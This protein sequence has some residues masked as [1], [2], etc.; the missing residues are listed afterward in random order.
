MSLLSKYQVQFGKSE[1]EY[2]EEPSFNPTLIFNCRF[3]D[4]KA[5]NYNLDDEFLNY[6][7]TVVVDDYK[8]QNGDYCRI[9]GFDN[10]YRVVD[11]QPLQTFDNLNQKYS[12]KLKLES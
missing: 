12:I 11:V 6:D 8:P 2:G 9:V 10:Y 1:L 5:V 7:G 3:F 4:K